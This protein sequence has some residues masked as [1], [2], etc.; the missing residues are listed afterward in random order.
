MTIALARRALELDEERSE[1][2]WRDNHGS[3]ASN[4]TVN[5]T[6]YVECLPA[7]DARVIA[8]AVTHLRELAE[9]VIALEN[10]VTLVRAIDRGMQLGAAHER[11]CGQ[12]Q[13]CNACDLVAALDALD[14]AAP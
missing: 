4:V 7:P 6:V 2:E 3:W 5:N 10:I 12:S 13:Q 9:R 1:G 14:E 8:F 11:G